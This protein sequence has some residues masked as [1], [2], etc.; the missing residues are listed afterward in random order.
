MVFYFSI[1]TYALSKLQKID[2]MPEK[3]AMK[4]IGSSFIRLIKTSFKSLI[5]LQFFIPVKV[6]KT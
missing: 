6:Y 4:N 1:K 3:F 5:F 2:G